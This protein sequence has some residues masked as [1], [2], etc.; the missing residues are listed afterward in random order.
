MKPGY[1]VID[2]GSTPGSWT[3]VAVEKCNSTQI[4]PTVLGIDLLEM[5]EGISLIYFNLFI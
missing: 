4:S 3:Q 5:N 1:K 2:L